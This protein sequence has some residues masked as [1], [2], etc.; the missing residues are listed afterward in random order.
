MRRESLGRLNV[1]NV[2][3]SGVEQGQRKLNGPQSTGRDYRNLSRPTHA[4]VEDDDVVVPMRDGVSLLA[5]V[6]RPAEQENILCW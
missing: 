5:D 1:N 3:A 6:H 4:M 2:P